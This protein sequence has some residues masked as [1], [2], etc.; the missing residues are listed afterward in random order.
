[1]RV[2][3]RADDDRRLLSGDRELR[4]RASRT[5]R[6]GSSRRVHVHACWSAKPQ[7]AVV[8]SPRDY[9]DTDVKPMPRAMRVLRVTF[10]LLTAAYW[11]VLCVLTHLPPKDL[12]HVEIDDKIQH[13]LSYGLLA[14]ML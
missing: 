13:F 2:S 3:C 10:W 12:P 5:N 6:R 14:G 11:V 1:M 9:A 8:S 4:R 7:A